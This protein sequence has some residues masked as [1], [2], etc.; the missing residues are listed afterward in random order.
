MNENKEINALRDRLDTT[1]KE[2]IDLKQL[3]TTK[4]NTKIKNINNGT[5]NNIINF[6]K[7]GNEDIK[8]FN[9]LHICKNIKKK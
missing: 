7:F 5:I 3:D 2:L 1:E 4:K 6:I 9:V 8:M